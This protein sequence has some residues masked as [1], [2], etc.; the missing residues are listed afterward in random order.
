MFEMEL[1]NTYRKLMFHPQSKQNIDIRRNKEKPV[2][3]G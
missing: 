3:D 2:D 1:R